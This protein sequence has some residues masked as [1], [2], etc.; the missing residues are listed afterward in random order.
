[1]TGRDRIVLIVIGALAVLGAAWLLLVSPERKQASKLEA[2][3]SAARA[4]LSSAEGQLADA[5]NAQAQYGKAYTAIVDLGKAVPVSQEVPSLIY[6]LEAASNLKRVNF[7]SITSGTGAGGSGP[8]AGGA[9]A[10]ASAS[11]ASGAAS[12]GFSQMPFTFTFEGGFFEL[13]KLFQKLNGF[14]VRTASGDVKV[15]GRLLTIQSVKLA[16]VN[17]S[18]G[19]SGSGKAGCGCLLTGNVTATAYTLPAGQ[20]LTG[21]ATPSGP[22]G[23]TGS[24]RS[25]STT[26]GVSSPATPATVR[27]NP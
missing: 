8:G 27:A 14:T 21:G 11:T 10:A 17:N 20:S 26:S 23:I 16:P 6:E 1:M 22:A 25:A 24:T 13:Y 4:E 9:G 12:A 19:S 3:V 5:R 2:Q 15:S 7:V 18:G